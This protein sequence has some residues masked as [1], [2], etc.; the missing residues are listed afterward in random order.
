MRAGGVKLNQN[1]IARLQIVGG[2]KDR[3]GGADRRHRDHADIGAGADAGNA[4]AVVSGNHF[5]NHRRAMVA[6]GSAS[7]DNGPAQS[8]L[9]VLMS[10][11]PLKLYV[12][13]LD[14]GAI[15]TRLGLGILG[16]DTSRGG[17]KII[18]IEL[19]IRCW[20]SDISGRFRNRLDIGNLHNV[21]L[22]ETVD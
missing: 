1:Q 5:A 14:T 6:V 9:Q 10:L 18:L 21:E 4:I 2:N 22:I 7:A 15:T 20:R 16:I 8:F 12:D 3:F 17:K 11:G 13:N 19:I